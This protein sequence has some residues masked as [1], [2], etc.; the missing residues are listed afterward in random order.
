MWEALRVFFA[1]NHAVDDDARITDIAPLCACGRRSPGGSTTRVSG[2]T[3][4]ARWV[5]RDPA[6]RP[7]S[8]GDRRSGLGGRLGP[9]PLRD[10][11]VA[12]GTADQM[13]AGTWTMTV[14]FVT[15]DHA[16]ESLP[17]PFRSPSDPGRDPK[18]PIPAH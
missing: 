14:Y 11:R 8:E 7:T 13:R 10:R 5:A 16:F 15:A 6:G 17:A 18:D 9:I 12:L 2:G 4:D 1:P 3:R